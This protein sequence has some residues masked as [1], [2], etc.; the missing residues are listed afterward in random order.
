MIEITRNERA[1]YG[2]TASNGS[3]ARFPLSF[4]TEH[5]VVLEWGEAQA[6][7]IWVNM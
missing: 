1:S 7:A 5:G 2:L 3:Y 6:K 4:E